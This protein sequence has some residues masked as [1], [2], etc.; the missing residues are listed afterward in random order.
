MGGS[1]LF[2][3]FFIFVSTLFVCKHSIQVSHMDVWGFS[4]V[5]SPNR[6]LN[7]DEEWSRGGRKGY[8]TSV[9]WEYSTMF[10]AETSPDAD[11]V[12]DLC[13]IANQTIQKMCE[14]FFDLFFLIS[15]HLLPM[16]AFTSSCI[17]IFLMSC[18]ILFNIKWKNI[19]F[20]RR[21]SFGYSFSHF[22]KH[23]EQWRRV[24]GKFESEI[25]ATSTTRSWSSMATRSKRELFS[26]AILCSIENTFA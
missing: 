19:T 10:G 4:W 14:H 21:S 25:S 9:K 23:K 8:Q 2:S 17:S 18:V 16:S 13:S 11:V 6:W 5:F 20:P 7:C 1:R 15:L 26:G 3:V 22:H 12:F 24:E